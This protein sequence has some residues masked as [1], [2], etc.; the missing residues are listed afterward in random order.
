MYAFAFHD[1]SSRPG[2]AAAAAATAPRLRAAAHR[3]LGAAGAG[4]HLSVLD[5]SCARMI[6]DVLVWLH[7]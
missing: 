7:L 6:A 4:I 1:A 5:S 2:H 3:R